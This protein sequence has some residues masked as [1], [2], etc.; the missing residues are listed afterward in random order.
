M[1]SAGERVDS[2]FSVAYKKPVSEYRYGHMFEF[3]AIDKTGQITV[4]YWGGP[5]RGKVEELQSSLCRGDVIRIVG[6]VSDFRDQLEISISEKNGGRFEH[7]KEGE[8]EMSG[9]LKVMDGIPEMK[10]R[11]MAFVRGVEEPHISGL[12]KRFFEDEEFME[13]FASCPASMQLHSAAVGGLLHHTLNVAEICSKVLLLQPNMDRDLVMAGAL[14]HDIGKIRSFSVGTSIDHTT[15]GNLIGHMTIGD[16]ELLE[17][18]KAIEGFPADLALKLRHV[19]ASHHGRKEWGSPVEPMMPEALLVHEADDL[20]AKLDYMVS[21]RA[22]AVTEDDWM[23]DKRLG[24]LIY[25]R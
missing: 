17:R 25:L 13:D 11:L 4:K 15:E 2:Y 16:E 5:D 12:L 3:R 6:E 23:W 9:L 1:L 21:R 7:L 22:D 14:L 20:D 19:V 10:E 24:R 18:L 8:Y